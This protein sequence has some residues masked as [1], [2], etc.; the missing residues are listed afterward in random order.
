[1]IKSSFF[2]IKLKFRMF[3]FLFILGIKSSLLELATVLEA[4]R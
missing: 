3:H 1:M 4:M 2:I